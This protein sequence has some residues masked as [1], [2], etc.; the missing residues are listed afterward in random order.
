MKKYLFY[1]LL[2]IVVITFTGCPILFKPLNIDDQIAN[3]GQKFQLELTQYTR[4]TNVESITY[5]V[6]DSVGEIEGK[7]YIWDDPVYENDGKEEVTI[8]AENERGV[9]KE[10]TFTITVNRKPDAPNLP[11]PSNDATDVSTNQVLEWECS[12]PED[13]SLTYDIYFGEDATPSLAKE[14]VDEKNYDPGKLKYETTYYWK[15]IVED[16]LGA[17]NEGPLWTFT[18]RLATRLDLTVTTSPD[19]GLDIS[20]DGED[21]KSPKTLPVRINTSVD[22]EV[23]SPQEI[24]RVATVTGVDTKY[25]FDQWNN[26]DDSYSRTATMTSNATY[27][28]NMN[29]EYK[30]ETGTHPEDFANIE[31]ADWYE[32][33]ATQTFT[34]SDT[35][36]AIFE[37]WKIN[38]IPAGTETTIEATVDSPKKVIAF[39]N[40]K[41]TIDITDQE[42]YEG[43]E[44]EI[45]LDDYASDPDGDPLTYSL[46]SGVGTI[47]DAIYTYSTDIDASGTYDVTIEAND[48]RE[49]T[50]EDTFTI[51]V[52]NVNEA[53][54]E[55]HSPIPTNEATNVSVN[56]ELEWECSDPDDDDLT[57]DI[58]FAPHD[59]PPKIAEDYDEKS[60][61]YSNYYEELDN[62]KMYYWKIVA[63][64]ENG[65]ETE[66]P[67]WL[68]TTEAN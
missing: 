4:A 31:G 62:E 68:F 56:L 20:I 2:A 37:R 36:E 55:P 15:V 54:N 27:T 8:S 45:D 44:L 57:Y 7:F 35:N 46:E 3:E 47:T 6:E 24:D 23:L 60:F 39:Y 33:D 34:A 9:K 64:D 50:A 21:Y 43:E 26:N 1:V 67:L 28:A 14:D 42:L 25:I 18:T 66:G 29:I 59:S 30:V 5:T 53:P 61:N 17:E 41:P 52:K 22:F 38:D 63:R 16:E 58:Y 51:T 49:G 19:T 13:Y 65:A 11:E 12:D 48:G 40:Q 32:V 10:D